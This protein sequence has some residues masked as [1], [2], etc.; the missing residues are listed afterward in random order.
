MLFR[1]IMKAYQLVPEAYGQEFAD[2]QKEPNETYVEFA[3]KKENLF[4]RW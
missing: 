2:S 3:R 1:S 4:D